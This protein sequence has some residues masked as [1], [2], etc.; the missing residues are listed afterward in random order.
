MGKQFLDYECQM[1][2]ILRGV[3]IQIETGWD[4]VKKIPIFQTVDTRSWIPD[5]L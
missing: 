1:N 3:G 5:P 4:S 2:R